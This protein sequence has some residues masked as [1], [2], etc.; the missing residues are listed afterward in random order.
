LVA[1]ANSTIFCKQ[2][3]IKY[4]G[5]NLCN[6]SRFAIVTDAW[7]CIFMASYKTKASKC[8]DDVSESRPCFCKTLTQL[9]MRIENLNIHC[10]N[11]VVETICAST[12]WCCKQW[13]C[14][15]KNGTKSIFL[16]W[17]S[18]TFSEMR[19]KVLWKH[20]T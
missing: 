20:F 15:Y 16:T 2:S 8:L 1:Q 9:L 5:L 3:N 12:A 4:F 18:F 13:A 7:L 6:V 14:S 19:L 11:A 17:Q 10:Y